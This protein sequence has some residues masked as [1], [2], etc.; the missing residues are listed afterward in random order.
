MAA[1]FATSCSKF[2]KPTSENEFVPT[3]VQ[4]LDEMLLF[5]TYSNATSCVVPYFDLLSD[6][7][8]VVKFASSESDLLTQIP[9]S[10]L[11]A[12]FTWQPDTYHKME[13]SRVGESVYDVY[14]GGYSRILGCNAV[15]DYIDT[16]EGEEKDR[17]QLCAEAHALRALWYF[18][19]V[20]TYGQPYNYNKTSLGVPLHLTSVVSSSSI[21]RNTVEEV[22]NLVLSDLKTAETLFESISAEWKKNM[23]VSLPFVQLLLSRVYL[24]ME[25]WE[26]S[27]TYAEKVMNNTN[28]RLIEAGEF[29]TTEKMYFH[30]YT[31]PEVIWPFA[32]ATE[33]RDFVDPYMFDSSKYGKVAFVVAEQGLLNKFDDTDI[34]KEHYFV[35]DK[36]SSYYKAFGKLAV[37]GEDENP[38]VINKFA[39]SFRLSEAYLNA[40][41]AHAIL[42]ME[43]KGDNHKTKAA[44]LLNALWAKRLP[45]VPDDYLDERSPARFVESVREERRRELCFEDHRWFDLR[46]YGMPQ[47]QH[48]WRGDNVDTGV[49]TYT[50]KKNDPMYTMQIPEG[51]MLLNPMLIQN[52]VGPIRVD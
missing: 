10:P 7:A 49:T 17:K 37:T 45:A 38:D 24:Y 35:Q 27:I 44:E 6:D 48:I 21:P 12:L 41:E 18:H 40:A 52:P 3:T 4:A 11:K 5:E 39:R 25:E 23:R 14:S 32:N 42:Y 8:A 47:I 30:S 46:R 22:Y 36:R 34:R 1:F 16:V 33:F 28:F 26:L 9:L 51:V 29:P 20:N 19:L 2:L 50:L 13:E 15:L 31:N 43:G